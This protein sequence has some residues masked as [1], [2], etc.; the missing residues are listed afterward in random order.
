MS[1]CVSVCVHVRVSVYPMTTW[2]TQITLVVL[3]NVADSLPLVI[4]TPCWWIMLS[5]VCECLLSATHIISEENS[6][7]TAAAITTTT[8]T[9]YYKKHKIFFYCSHLLFILGFVNILYIMRVCHVHRCWIESCVFLLCR[10]MCFLLVACSI[11]L[12]KWI[13]LDL[14]LQVT[15]IR[16]RHWE[17]WEIHCS[18]TDPFY[19]L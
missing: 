7:T 5:W 15:Q 10:E 2:K 17:L 4:L 16:R 12:I 1:E 9:F 18:S 13:S 6:R 14:G 19:L 8:L 3:W 11:E